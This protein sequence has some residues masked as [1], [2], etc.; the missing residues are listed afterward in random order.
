MRRHWITILAFTALLALACAG[1]ATAYKPIIIKEGNWPLFLNGG[2][3]PTKLPKKELAPARLALEGSELLAG[4][5]A[6][7]EAIFEVDKNVAFNARGLAVCRPRPIDLPAEPGDP[8]KEAR[9]G[10]G[11]MEFEIE[12]PETPPFT[13]KSHVVAYN[14]GKPGGVRTIFALG[15]LQNPVSAAVVIRIDVT[16]IDHGRYGTKLVAT[17]P[18]GGRQL[19]LDQEIPARILPPLRHPQAAL[20]PAAL[21][22]SLKPRAPRRRPRPGCGPPPPR[23]ARRGAASAG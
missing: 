8:C 12:F 4:P 18:A 22:G 20:H 10:K 7:K 11:E 6:L 2:F 23:G 16:K 9:V 17:I 15:Y 21:I 19:R 14:G 3:A 5:A 13:E 1:I